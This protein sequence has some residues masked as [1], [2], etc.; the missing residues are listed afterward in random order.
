VAELKAK[1]DAAEFEM[2]TQNN[3]ALM[4]SNVSFAKLGLSFS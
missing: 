1:N 4:Q 2:E 3:V